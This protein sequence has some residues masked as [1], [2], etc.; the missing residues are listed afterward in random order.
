MSAA[1]VLLLVQFR[2]GNSSRNS[3]AAAVGDN[4]FIRPQSQGSAQICYIH[5]HAI[6]RKQK[7]NQK[8][9]INFCYWNR[10]GS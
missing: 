8:E 1:F 2:L 7:Q 6:R 5:R 4:I 9:K 10:Q 3:V